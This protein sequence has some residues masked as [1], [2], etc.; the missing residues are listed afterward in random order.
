MLDQPHVVAQHDPANMLGVVAQLPEQAST[1]I[2]VESTT[3]Q[4][5]PAI[6]AVVLA[7]MGGSALAADVIAALLGNQ[8]AIPLVVSKGYDIPAFVNKTTL[9]ITI[10]HSGN[11]EETLSCYQQAQERQAQLVVLSSGGT[12]LEWTARDGVPHV[13]I[14]TGWQPRMATIFHLRALA[15]LLHHC[16]VIDGQLYQ[17]IGDNADWLAQQVAAWAPDVPTADNYAKQLAMLTV[18]KI[19]VFL[20][21]EITWPLAYKWKISWNESA[22]NIAFCNR[23][24][25]FSHNEFIGW[26]S[27]PVEK[28]FAVIDLRSQLERPR[29]RQRMELSDKLLSGKRPKAHPVELVGKTLVQQM[30]WGLALADAASIYTAILNGVNPEPVALVE[31]LK[32][33]L[34]QIDQQ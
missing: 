33:E 13:R 16:G 23:Y 2:T 6:E 32:H 20:A 9:V 19:P 18:G 7:G 14:P 24:P 3:H 27:H 11:T 21:G 25:E 31:R 22:K 4:S 10:S 29:I 26:S 34:A 28:P 1:D 15:K 5:S 8:L 12:L 30:L 17:Q